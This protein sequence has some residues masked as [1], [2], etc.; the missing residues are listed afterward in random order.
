[1]KFLATKL[2]GAFIIELDRQ[3]DSRGFFARVFCAREFAAQGL[4]DR[5]VQCSISLTRKRGTLRGLHYQRQPAAEVKLVRCI[6]G[7]MYDVIV[8]LRPDS[9]TYLQYVGAEL[10]RQN[11]RA[12]YVPKMFAHGYQTLEDDTEVLYEID[13]YYAPETA[14]GVRYND[15]R[16]GIQWPLS[17]TDLSE[18]DANWPLLT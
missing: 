1:M 11:H 6:A 18:K 14:T 16:L 8:D 17:V 7:A 13:E 5:F 2:D 12:L 15:P 3:E 10:T 9:P 4:T